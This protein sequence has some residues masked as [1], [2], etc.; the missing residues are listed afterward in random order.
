MGPNNGGFPVEPPSQD[1]ENALKKLQN[2]EKYLKAKEEVKAAEA[3]A[4]CE[5]NRK[6]ARCNEARL[7]V[8]Y[9]YILCIWIYMY[10]QS[11][12]SQS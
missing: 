7:S 1:L 10:I 9:I 6:P 4:R 12:K 2:D 3:Q 11:Y 5:S 8:S